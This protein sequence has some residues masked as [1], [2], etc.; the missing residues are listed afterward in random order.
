MPAAPKRKLSWSLPRMTLSPELPTPVTAAPCKMRCS[1]SP[2]RVIHRSPDP[3]VRA[4]AGLL[5][6]DVARLSEAVNVIAGS[7][8]HGVVPTSPEYCVGWAET[9]KRKENPETVSIFPNALSCERVVIAP[10][11]VPAGRKGSVTVVTYEPVSV[12]VLASPMSSVT[13]VP[14]PEKR[15][16]INPVKLD[17]SSAA[18]SKL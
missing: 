4:L 5:D 12:I 10:E 8:L 2:A 7:A 16:P 18:K 15:R 13:V 1:T 17:E 9:S 6:H 11:M 3:I 14:E